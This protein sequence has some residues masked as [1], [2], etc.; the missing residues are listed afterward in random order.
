MHR[1]IPALVLFAILGTEQPSSAAPAS[2][3]K[4]TQEKPQTLPRTPSDSQ[5]EQTIKAK[6]AKSKL[7]SDHFTVSVVRG[8]ATIE[9][10]TSVLQHKG[11]MTRMAKASGATSVLNN[12]HVSDAAKAK[13]AD[14][15]AQHR[16]VSTVTSTSSAASQ[17][18]T[19]TPLPRATVLPAGAAH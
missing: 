18:V 16:A 5:I 14:A 15:L 3:A 19:S 2:A 8:V 17:P 4:Q 9:G 1:F 7:R 12:I 13:A 11:A 10:S 6:L